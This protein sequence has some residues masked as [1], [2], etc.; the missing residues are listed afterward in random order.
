MPSTLHMG[1]I[2][3]YTKL[4]PVYQTTEC[5]VSDCDCY[6]TVK[7][8]N[9]TSQNTLFVAGVRNRRIPFQICEV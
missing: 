6:T 2:G 1:T 8:Q 9:S 7:T 5:H 4:V 3:S